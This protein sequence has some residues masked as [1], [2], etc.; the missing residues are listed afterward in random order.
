MAVLTLFSS[1]SVRQGN[2]NK[3]VQWDKCNIPET[4]MEWP[5]GSIIPQFAEMADTLDAVFTDA[6]GMSRSK[7]LM[8]TTLQGNINKTRPRIMCLKTARGGLDEWADKLGIKVRICP[9]E[10]LFSLVREYSSEISGIVL[11]DTARSIHYQNLAS[12]VASLTNSIAMTDEEYSEARKEGI[13]LKVRADLR[14]LPFTEA[15]DIYR[16]MYEN[17]RDSFTKRILLSLSPNVANDIR[18][19]AVATKAATIWLDPRVDEE[20]EVLRLFLQDMKAGESIILGWWPEERSGIGAGTSYGI[21][22]IPSDF[23]D[24]STVYASW[25]RNISHAPVPTR[26]ALENKV[27]IALFL[28]D[29]D[30][31]QYCEHTMPK[32]WA[33]PDR[34]KVPVNW[35]A[36]P[37]LAE[38][39][40][41]LLD[42]YYRTATENDCITCGPSGLGYALIYDAHNK[43][44][45]TSGREFIDPYT[46]LSQKYLTMSGMRVITIWDELD[47]SQMESYAENCRYLYGLTQQD[48]E[49]G[50][51]IRA[52]H[53]GNRIAVLPN[54]PCYVNNVDAIYNSW[55]DT[56][57]TYSG[58]YPLFL[59]AQVVSW[60]V[61][62]DKMLE[63]KEKLEKLAPGKIELCR[64]DHFFSLY[65]EAC[66]LDFNLAMSGS[67]AITASSSENDADKLSDGTS[68]QGYQWIAAE[69][70]RQS[71]TF[72]FPETYVIDR[73]VIRHVGSAGEDSRMNTRDFEV[74]VSEDGVNWQSVDRQRGNISD[75]SDID[76]PAVEARYVRIDITGPGKG[77]IARIGDVEIYGRR[78]QS[79]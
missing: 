9:A 43:V 1:C 53:I 13:V 59:T 61:G 41:G 67:T 52:E 34:G 73:Y 66:G 58:N 56:I 17:Y 63:L 33:D 25:D 27:Y 29:G 49:R 11:Y 28:S 45:M 22:T 6:P 31:I 42:Y 77:N 39:G 78:N 4:G 3:F 40:P 10:E 74:S 62:P 54:K 15:K 37:G 57:S 16:Y 72:G 46:A 30:N 60:K 65:N 20:K 18:D 21:S 44:W 69:K 8:L 24:N 75:V 14:E 32:L 35:T 48:W 19:M 5:E 50:N 51:P 26:P 76:I 36:S 7:V 12:T 47:R 38:L 71:I 79:K 70:G 2:E 68:A 64:A 23:Y 55:K